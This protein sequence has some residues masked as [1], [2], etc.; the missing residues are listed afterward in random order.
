MWH[1]AVE[2]ELRGLLRIPDDVA[3]SACITLGRPRGAHGPVRRRPLRDMVFE[4]GWGETTKWA[5]DPPGTTHTSAGPK[6]MTDDAS[7]S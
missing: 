4:D 3:L 5:T 2:T 7:G 1:H 6:S